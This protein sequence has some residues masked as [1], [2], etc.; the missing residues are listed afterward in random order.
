MQKE[1]LSVVVF[2]V[3][4]SLLSNHCENN[5]DNQFQTKKDRAAPISTTET[6][7]KTET[8]TTLPEAGS[9]DILTDIEINGCLQKILVQSDDLSKPLLLY[10]HGGPGDP[11]MLYSHLYSDILKGRLKY[12]FRYFFEGRGSAVVPRKS[13]SG[14]YISTIPKRN[15]IFVN[16]D[17]RG[18]GLSWHKGMDSCELHRH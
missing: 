5:T 12:Y 10:I 3:C 6:I 7:G 4:I 9:I 14:S 8:V 1:I 2:T 11:A 15:F 13:F 17:Q 16:W 18:S